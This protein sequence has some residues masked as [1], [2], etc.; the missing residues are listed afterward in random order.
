[1]CDLARELSRS[2]ML[3]VVKELG[4]RIL[5]YGPSL[6]HEDH[7]ISDLPRKTHFVCHAD[8]GHHLFGETDHCIEDLRN[9]LGHKHWLAIDG[10]V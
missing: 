5:L 10:Q 1:M 9:H 3:R 6:V 8:H 4:W 2:R 7:S